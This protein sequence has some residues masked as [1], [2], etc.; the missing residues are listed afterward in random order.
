MAK[1][2]EGGTAPRYQ[3]LQ[4]SPAHASAAAPAAP[5]TTAIAYE[6]MALPTKSA[7]GR[8]SFMS[9]AH[10]RAAARC[11]RN[12]NESRSPAMRGF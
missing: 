10:G 5:A 1:S 2:S 3:R 9:A 8:C 12:Q 4:R 7:K 11:A 6:S